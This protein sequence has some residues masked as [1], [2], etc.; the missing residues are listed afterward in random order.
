MI[1]T[2]KTVYLESD[3]ATRELGARV[4]RCCIP[5]LVIFLRGDLGSGKTTFAR[6]FVRELGYP[7]RVKSPTFS[8]EESYVFEN[9]SLFH[10]D[11]YRI[12]SSHEVEFIGIRDVMA[13]EDAVCL[14]EWPERRRRGS[15][16]S[17]FGVCL[18]P[19]GEWP[20]CFVAG[21]VSSRRV[22]YRHVMRLDSNYGT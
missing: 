5:P 2:V 1:R 8:L 11:L 14:I 7:G 6:G 21:Q 22:N 4:A 16:G 20:E 17:R 9:M 19:S 18:C 10:F 12:R 15:T 13:R 3:E